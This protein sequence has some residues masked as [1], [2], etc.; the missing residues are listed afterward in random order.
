MK[1]E[2]NI[3]DFSVVYISYDE[4]NCEKHWADLLEKNPAAKRV[5]HVKGFDAAHRAAGEAGT[6]DRIITVDAD[7]II[8]PEFM[9][10]KVMIDD[11]LHHD[12]VYSWKGLNMVNGLSYGNGG[13]KLWPRD[14]L[15]N[16]ASHEL[17]EDGNGVD[18]CWMPTYVQMASIWSDVYVNGSPFQAF[19]A[20][21]R[22]GVKM[23]LH[24][25]DKVDKWKFY[26][27]NARANLER[28]SIWCSVGRDILH[29]NYAMI[30]ARMGAVK[31]F[32][33]EFEPSSVAEFD[34]FDTVWDQHR[35]IFN[36]PHTLK[37]FMLRLN[38]EINDLMQLRV[39]ELDEQQ[40]AWF[41]SV[42]FDNKAKYSIMVT[43]QEAAGLELKRMFEDSTVI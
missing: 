18:F 6:T 9:L 40:S 7:N 8:H 19:R 20:G 33:P 1:Q 30:G 16:M 10:Q 37:R 39:A 5:H 34:Y 3:S 25:G 27:K 31:A 13:L 42:H 17:A 24:N 32:D 26:E 28:L 14:E 2:Y 36:D 15:L 23:S 12:Y 38:E 41:K 21:Y 43:E 35:A 4:P 11:E 29:G 22:E